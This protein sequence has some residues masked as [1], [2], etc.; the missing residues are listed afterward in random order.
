MRAFAIGAALTV[1]SVAAAS[2]APAPPE[3]T[4]D[5][6]SASEVQALI[7][8]AKAKRTTELNYPQRLLHLAPYNA[9]LEYRAVAGTAAVHEHEAEVFVVIEGAGVLTTGGKL[10]AETRTNA[11]NLSGTGITGGSSRRIAKG[12]FM[13]V[14][15]NVPHWFSEITSGP[16]VLMAFHVPR[17]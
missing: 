15:E 4:K 6:T 8:N 10:I 3:A 7:A 1:L 12:D 13:I 16:L 17:G 11:D 2:A 9:N 14:P 5:F